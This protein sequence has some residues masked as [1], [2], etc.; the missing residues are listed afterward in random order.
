MKNKLTFLA[1]ITLL[2]LNVVFAQAP[3]ISPTNGA[4]GVAQTTTTFTWTAIAA[5]VNPNLYDFEIH[6]NSGYSSLLEAG[7]V[8]SVG[9]VSAIIVTALAY[10]TTYYW[11]VRDTDNNDDGVNG[12]ADNGLWQNFSFTTRIATP[13]VTGPTG[14]GVSVNPTATWTFAGGT[15]GVTFDIDYSSNG[16]GS[17]NS[18]VAGIAGTL[19][20]RV[21]TNT[22]LYNQAYIIRVTAK[23][24]LEANQTGTGASFTTVTIPAPVITSPTDLQT[25][26]IIT[27]TFTWTWSGSGA[28]TYNVQVATDNGFTTIVYN[29]A[30]NETTP[31]TIPDAS[32]LTNGTIYYVR[33]TATQGSN[34]TTSS[35]IQFTTI[36]PAIPQLVAPIH[37]STLI[38]NVVYFS[39]Y[40][41]VSGVQY[42][43][44]LSSSSGFGSFVTGF[45]TAYTSLTN[46]NFPF[47]YTTLPA[48]DYYWRVKSYTLTGTLI[49]ISSIWRFTVP[50]P[51]TA[52]LSYPTGGITVYTTSPTVYWYLNNYFYTSGIYYRIKYGTATTVY[53]ITTAT[54]TNLYQ[55]IPGLTVGQTYYYVIDA[56]TTSGFGSFTTSLEGS[57]VVYYSTASSIPVYQS[58]PIGGQTVY[59]STPTLYW[60]LGLYIPGVTFDIDVDNTSNFSTALEVNVTG[61]PGYSYPTASLSDGN[62][63]WRIKVTGSS[64]W[65][66]TESFVINTSTGYTGATIPTPVSPT[67]GTVVTTQSPSLTWYAY[68]TSALEYQL[69]YSSNPTLSGGGVLV[70]ISSPNGGSTGWLVTNSYALSGL[71]PGVTYYWQVRSRLASTP[72]TVSN[73]SSVA[74]FTVSPGAS[75]VV[76]L[77]ANPI[78]GMNLNST[79]VNLSWLVP[80]KSESDLSYD[81]ELSKNSDMSSALLV[82]N[83]KQPSYKATNLE[84]NSTYYWRAR[85]KTSTQSSNYSAIS[86]FKTGGVTDVPNEQV[87]PTSFELSQ[88]YPNPFNPTTIITYS[89]PQNSF[90][91]IKVYDM[92]GREVRSLVNNEML[93][94]NHS[95]EWS[96]MDNAGSKV[97][98]GTYIY[99]ITAGSFVAVKKMILIK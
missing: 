72:A 53:T 47:T 7:Q 46:Y 32:A 24:D 14:T 25:G 35:V 30:G 1:L 27:P 17:W 95:I 76:V 65:Y 61:V 21:F 43:V 29:P 89:L 96:G 10:N 71:T 36:A 39:W 97:A 42:R 90:V 49:S 64:T 45:P 3:A 56:S 60:Y 78:I 81:L 9:G 11:R 88:N 83:L 40:T 28:V 74:Q 67:G 16:G 22:L 69:I 13:S 98:S 66:G 54:T 26:V 91:S 94:G 57:F 99:R 93:A 51:P 87:I 85:S 38:G 6:T 31:W 50:G 73:Y 55:T 62:Y 70:N 34:S 37:L 2:S 92:L 59:T 48:G 84:S 4:T 86:S 77:P 75:P 23:K 79:A 58:Y 80:A 20:S 52:I 33:V 41:G 82:N 18:E 44:E 19:T 68:S 12:G 5:G 8:I 63:W 15:T